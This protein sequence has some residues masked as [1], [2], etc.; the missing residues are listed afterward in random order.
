MH[1]LTC[2]LSIVLL[3]RLALSL[4]R[5]ALLTSLCT[6]S[7]HLSPVDDD[8]DVKPKSK[9][10]SKAKKEETDSDSE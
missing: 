4:P 1:A 10:K 8:A 7:N 5:R 3:V 9:S 6:H 2:L